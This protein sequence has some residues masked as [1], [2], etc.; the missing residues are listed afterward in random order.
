[1]CVDTA[2]TPK[3]CRRVRPCGVHEQRQRV[4]NSQIRMA[5]TW[6]AATCSDLSNLLFAMHLGMFL[7]VSRSA[8]RSACAFGQCAASEYRRRV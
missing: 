7:Q 8:T 1:M 6:P 5:A 4:C 3:C 2:V